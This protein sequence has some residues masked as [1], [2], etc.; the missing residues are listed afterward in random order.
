[1]QVKELIESI[2]KKCDIELPEGTNDRL[3]VGTQDADVT[4]IAVTFMATV[5]VIRHAVDAGLNT[6]I[7]HEPVYY[8]D[9][10]R[11]EWAIE[12]E[13]YQ[14][15]NEIIQQNQLNIYRLHDQLHLLKP[16]LIYEGMI[17]ELGWS[18]YVHENDQRILDLPG[19]SAKVLA[20]HIKEKLNMPVIRLVGSTDTVCNRAGLLVGA[21]S[22]GFGMGHGSEESPMKWM[23]KKNVDVLLCGE[24][25]EWT[26]CAYVRDAGILDIN[27]AAIV[28]GHNR[29]EEAG[30]KHL[31]NWLKSICGNIT[32][33]FIEAGDPF[34]YL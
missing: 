18:D 15:K 29:S 34:V 6:I 31:V 11:T 1:M 12:D 8:N 20:E 14:T 22:L 33:S 30:M 10:D 13:V 7:T 5:D 2:N 9:K 26:S 19:W 16:D 32:V 23:K 25:I 17:T 27:R 4:G 21:L 3:I 24:M 28:L